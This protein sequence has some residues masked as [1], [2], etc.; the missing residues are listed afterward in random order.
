M[1]RIARAKR[2]DRSEPEIVEALRRAGC[3]VHLYDDPL[4]LLV[5]YRGQT[6]LVEVKDGRMPPSERPLKPSQVAFFREWTGGPAYVVRSV[7]EALCV[8]GIAPHAP[9][10]GCGSVDDPAW[11]T[12]MRAAE[13]AARPRKPQRKRHTAKEI[14]A[15]IKA[16]TEGDLWTGPETETY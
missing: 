2:R 1:K 4:D 11:F 10:C 9:G 13:V 5:G 6:Y 14:D 15:A 16:A 8:L 12:A 7:A 3:Y